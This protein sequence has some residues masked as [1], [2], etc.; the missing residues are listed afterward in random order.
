MIHVEL[1][2]DAYQ[3][4]SDLKHCFIGYDK[5]VYWVGERMK[6]PQVKSLVTMRAPDKWPDV[7]DCA[8]RSSVTW[9]HAYLRSAPS[10]QSQPPNSKS[11]EPLENQLWTDQALHSKKSWDHSALSDFWRDFYRQNM[12]EISTHNWRHKQK[13]STVGLRHNQGGNTVTV[14]S[15]KRQLR[16]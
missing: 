2:R 8:H 12:A 14:R 7:V 15:K 13:G 10:R 1:T 3:P 9:H 4:S 11:S 5:P 6:F 16:Y